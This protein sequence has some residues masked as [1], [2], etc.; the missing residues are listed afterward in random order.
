[1]TVADKRPDAHSSGVARERP[2]IRAAKVLLAS[3]VIASVSGCGTMTGEHAY[4]AS[5]W[6]PLDPARTADGCPNL[7]GTYL[8]PGN[9]A[10]P[11]DLGPPPRLSDIFARMAEAGDPFGR[12]GRGAVRAVPGEAQRVRIDQTEA[13]LTVTFLKDDGASHTLRFR[14]YHFD[15]SETRYDDLFTCYADDDAARVRFFPELGRAAGAS[16]LYAGGTAA[17]VFLLRGADGSLVVQVRTEAVGL[18]LLAVGSQ[19]G[20]SSTWYRYPRT[21][22]EATP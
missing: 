16:P 5:S 17:L 2:M 18:S 4:P 11:G 7:S 22:G 19:F 3:V 14:R 21:E 20:F 15:L 6:G 8:D 10:Y 13:A 9:A 1:V 12:G